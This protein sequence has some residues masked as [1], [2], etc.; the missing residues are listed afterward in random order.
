[1]EEKGRRQQWGMQRVEWVVWRM[2]EDGD[3]MMLRKEEEPERWKA[4]QWRRRQ[5]GLGD[6]SYE[7]L[8]SCYDYSPGLKLKSGYSPAATRRSG[9]VAMNLPSGCRTMPGCLM[10]RPEQRGLSSS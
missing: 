10:L 3:R 2:V 7:Q 6:K 8:S 5:D 9:L 4:E 1:M